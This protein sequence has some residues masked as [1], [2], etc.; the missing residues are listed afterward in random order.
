MVFGEIQ[1]MSSEIQL[2]ILWEKAREKEAELLEVIENKF[3]VLQTFSIT[4]TPYLVSNNFTRFYGQSLPANSHK[5]IHCGSG[6][7]RLIVV[8][9]NHPKYEIRKTS[10]GNR[11]VNINMFDTKT[12]LRAITDGG[13]KIHGTD[14]IN[15]TRHNIA[16]LLG[17]SLD[18]FLEKYSNRKEDIKLKQ[19]LVGTLG[20]ESFEQ[21]FYILNQC[22]DYIV[23]RNHQNINLKYFKNNSGDIDILSKDSME[24]K[25]ILGDLKNVKNNHSKVLIDE[26][27]VLFEVDQYGTNLICKDWEDEIF[28]TKIKSN[29]IYHPT[30]DN[31]M[32][33]L[34]YHA[35]FF[36]NKL[37]DKHIKRILERYP[38]HFS[39]R[40]T[41]EIDLIKKLKNFLQKND[42]KITPPN[43]GY[44]NFR[45]EFEK[46]Y[47]KNKNRKSKVQKLFNRIINISIKNKDININLLTPIRKL[48][49][50]EVLIPYICTIRFKIG[51]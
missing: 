11:T 51:K 27:I 19:D 32:Y 42:F 25:F 15:E 31:E 37:E 29:H 24:T 17:M 34:I 46:F 33:L 4:W 9:D 49:F 21:L 6:E 5:E 41:L 20:W 14:N 10:K 35:L 47:K 13:H 7:F 45:P 23:L 30:K 2:F 12:Q 40:D 44:F 28:G 38:E 3:E 26:S 43:N 16:M 39:S 48:V 1:L 36:K 8:K 22:S 18:D 50:I